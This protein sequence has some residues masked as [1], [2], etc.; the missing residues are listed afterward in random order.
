MTAATIP[1]PKISWCGIVIGAFLGG[2]WGLYQSIIIVSC[3]GLFVRLILHSCLIWNLV[4]VGI[5]SVNYYFLDKRLRSN[6][7]TQKATILKLKTVPETPSPFIL[8]RSF[9]WIELVDNDDGMLGDE[10]T[11]AN[12][13]GGTLGVAQDLANKDSDLEQHKERTTQDIRDWSRDHPCVIVP[14]DENVQRGGH[15]TV[16]LQDGD[17]S[18]PFYW[19]SLFLTQ[20]RI[21]KGV[22]KYLIYCFICVLLLHIIFGGAP[23]F[24]ASS[25]DVEDGVNGFWDRVLPNDG[26]DEFSSLDRE[27]DLPCQIPPH[28]AAAYDLLIILQFLLVIYAPLRAY[29]K[30]KTLWGMEDPPADS[31]HLLRGDENDDEID[32]KEGNSGSA[33]RASRVVIAV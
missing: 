4:F 10:S 27:D 18:K 14:I 13:N 33:E 22:A 2:L 23:L 1:R 28:V 8:Q 11:I 26:D 7:P 15:L 16:H 17:P 6:F 25:Q 3:Y 24:L 9:C 29:A 12:A 32:E 19:R 30:T 21:K 31:Y 20:S 5:F